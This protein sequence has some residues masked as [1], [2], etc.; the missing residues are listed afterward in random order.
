MF[1]GYLDQLTIIFKKY[2]VHLVRADVPPPFAFQVKKTKLSEEEKYISV[3]K[4][5]FETVPEQET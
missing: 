4:Y 3:V 2:S 5:W 1:Q